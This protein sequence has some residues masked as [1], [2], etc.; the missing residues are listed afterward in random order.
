MLDLF[1]RIKAALGAKQ[2]CIILA[3]GPQEGSSM[4]DIDDFF[5]QISIQVNRA[6]LSGNSVMLVGDFNAKLGKGLIKGDVH[7]ISANGKKFQSVLQYFDMVAVNSLCLC[8]DVFTRVNNNNPDEKSVLDYVCM[9]KD[10]SDLLLSMYVD[11]K[12]MYTL[13]RKLKRGKKYTDHNAILLTMKLDTVLHKVGNQNRKTIWN[14]RDPQGWDKFYQ[15]TQNDD[16]LLNVWRENDSLE[17][18][19]QKWHKRLNF[20]FANVLRKKEL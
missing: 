11:E 7:G 1:I 16:Q 18:R 9:S 5:T 14:F 12:K 10:I 17:S 20:L 19:Y 15:L 6:I 2:I 13:W 3:Y 8:N 4:Q